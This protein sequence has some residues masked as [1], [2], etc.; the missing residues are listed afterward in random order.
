MHRESNIARSTLR[1]TL[2]GW[3]APA[4]DSHLAD[5]MRR[6]KSP[7]SEF[8][9]LLWSAWVFIT[10]AFGIGYGRTWLLLT[11]LSYPLFLWLYAKTYVAP[12]RRARWYPLAMVA[13]S[14]ALLRWYPSGLS[15]FVFGCVLLVPRRNAPGGLPGYL[16]LVLS[17]G[18][19]VVAEALWIGYPWQSVVWLPPMTLVIGLIVG[20]EQRERENEAALRLSH[21]EVR[22]LAATAERER[23]GRDLHD[24]LGHTLS[25][26]TLKLELSRKLIDRDVAAARTE[27][28]EAE[29]VARHALAEVRGAVTGFRAADLAAEL[30]SAR[31]LLESSAVALEYDP[32]PELSP[33][34]ERPLAL[35]LRE[36]ATNIARHAHASRAEVR[37]VRDAAQLTM[38]I[39]D[40]GRGAA[41]AEGNGVVGM[42]ERM[43]ALG[44]SFEFA[45]SKTG[46][47]VEVAVP[48]PMAGRHP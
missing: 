22:R 38:R 34:I 35:V 19:A 32:P 25:L 13:L 33:E 46:T 12:A 21:E 36:A 31:L 47:A 16:A 24:L 20:V 8:I 1:A 17:L 44:G 2:A 42:R 45:T 15:Y 9:H 30:A 23:I 29:D 39:A 7:R 5:A 3:F 6:G 11:L 40:D 41:A 14:M 10:P 48:L 26:I 4:P 27:I 28:A 37:F 43:R 18:A